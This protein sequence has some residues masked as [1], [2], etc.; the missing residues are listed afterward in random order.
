V[1]LAP[2]GG[3]VTEPPFEARMEMAQMIEAAAFG[4]VADFG[5]GIAQQGGRPDQAQLHSERRHGPAEQLMKQAVQLTLTAG[6]MFREPA[7]R[8]GLKLIS[9]ELFE[10]LD[11]VLLGA[12]EPAPL[13]AGRGLEFVGQK[14]CGHAQQL[15]P[16]IEIKLRWSAGHESMS[17]DGQRTGAAIELGCSETSRD[18]LE[19]GDLV[20]GKQGEQV[21]HRDRKPAEHQLVTADFAAVA[22]FHKQYIPGDELLRAFSREVF[23]GTGPGK[24]EG[25]ALPLRGPLVRRVETAQ[26]ES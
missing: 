21:L 26:P 3:A 24:D 1:A 2:P 14:D 9:C 17:L 8:H 23:A 12:D 25:K 11:R 5:L 13:L 4:D 6:E 16:M 10:H 15:A 20:A 7:D 19:E 18:A 22:S